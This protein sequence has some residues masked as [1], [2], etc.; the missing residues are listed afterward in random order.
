M[1]RIERVY[2]VVVS[3]WCNDADFSSAQTI[4]EA[5]ETLAYHN[6]AVRGFVEERVT[7]TFQIFKWTVRLEASRERAPE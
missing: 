4:A 7:V 3:E 5:R 2:M 6:L 1:P